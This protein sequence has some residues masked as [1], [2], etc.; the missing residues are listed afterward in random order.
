M[1]FII[2][3]KEIMRFTLALIAA[4]ILFAD[5]SEARHRRKNALRGKASSKGDD[6]ATLRGGVRTFQKKDKDDAT[7]ENTIYLYG[8]FF[9]TD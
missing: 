6:T 8:R 7:I 2:L 4:A 1:F 3:K 9:E 5:S